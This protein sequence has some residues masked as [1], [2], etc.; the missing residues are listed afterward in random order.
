MVS[1]QHQSDNLG[2]DDA[3]YGEIRPLVKD[4]RTIITL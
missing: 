4:L 1:F 2:G 3:L